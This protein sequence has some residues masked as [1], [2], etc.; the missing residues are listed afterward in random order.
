M[1]APRPLMILIT[2][3]LSSKSHK[4]A[5]WLETCA[6]GHHI[7]NTVCYP[8]VRNEWFRLLGFGVAHSISHS[9]RFQHINYHVPQ[10]ERRNSC[11][12][13]TSVQ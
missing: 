3:S 4:D 8:L 7:V 13:H 6:F 5:R 1:D 11:Q 12:S 9:F 2:A 10:S